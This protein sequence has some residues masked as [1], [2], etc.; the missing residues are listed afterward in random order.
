VLD[1]HG[2]VGFSDVLRRLVLTID[3]EL[4]ST[5]FAERVLLDRWREEFGVVQ[6]SSEMKRRHATI[7]RHLKKL[8]LPQLPHVAGVEGALKNAGLL[9]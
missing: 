4:T 8:G 3:A 7:G 5:T 9:R 2:V 1:L 6:T